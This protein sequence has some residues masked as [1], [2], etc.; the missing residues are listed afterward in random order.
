MNGHFH[1]D[2]VGKADVDF[3]MA[4]RWMKGH[5]LELQAV[6][7]RVYDFPQEVSKASARRDESTSQFTLP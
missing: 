4:H 5:L 6:E 1:E 3:L 7:W 2:L